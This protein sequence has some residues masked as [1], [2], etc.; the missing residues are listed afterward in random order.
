MEKED[1]YMKILY[2]GSAELYNTTKLLLKE[3]NSTNTIFKTT[4]LVV[5]PLLFTY[6]SWVLNE[7]KK[8]NIKRLYFLARD[9]YIMKEIADLIIKHE[10][11]NIESKYLYCSRIAW[12]IPQ[13]HL[14]KERCL[15]KIF[16]NSVEVNLDKIF[17]RACLSMT[18]RDEI[19]EELKIDEQE[20]SRHLQWYEVLKYKEIFS[21]NQKF[22]KF[23]YKHSSEHYETTVGYLKQEGLYDNI[24][25]AIVDTG[26]TGSMQTSLSSLLNGRKLE[27]FYFGIYNLPVEADK[28]AFHS[29]Y[30]NKNTD[31]RNKIFFNNNLFECLCLSPDGMTIAYKRENDKFVPIFSSISN[32]NID[33]W[34]INLHIET[35]LKFTKLALKQE[36]LK[37]YNYR[38]SKK[39][40]RMLCK[41]FMIYPSVEESTMYGNFKFSDD[42][43]EMNIKKLAVNMTS[44][45]IK[46]NFLL[47]RLANRL[48]VHK[49]N[50]PYKQSCWIEASIRNNSKITARKY[51]WHILFFRWVQYVSIL[52][53]KRN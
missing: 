4:A 38:I 44:Q 48:K 10:K 43:T 30:F 49:Y 37:E 29:F 31:I 51:I 25:Y 26:W 33:I 40:V 14:E 28:K 8:K 6:I 11:L 23:I 45:E 53:L 9:G 52:I 47:W 19:I 22:L 34:D 3:G 32:I 50:I 36:N 24:N 17:D 27:G 5:A 12:R 16:I 18:E 42:I 39:M 2:R 35:I 1:K 20:K 21:I 13:Y 41:E 46:Q 7:A 15:D